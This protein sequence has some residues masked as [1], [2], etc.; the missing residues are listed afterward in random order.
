MTPDRVRYETEDGK[1]TYG[2]TLTGRGEFDPANY[3]EISVTLTK[4]GH[5]LRIYREASEESFAEPD[6]VWVYPQG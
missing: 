5:T 1:V 3:A 2:G 6:A 4:G